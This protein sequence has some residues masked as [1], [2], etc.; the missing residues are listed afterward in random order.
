M[1]LAILVVGKGIG[2]EK[3]ANDHLL[4]FRD[5]AKAPDGI[6]SLDRYEFVL[7]HLSPT[8]PEASDA[9]KGKILGFS[10][11]QVPENLRDFEIPKFEGLGGRPSILALPWSSVP[12]NFS[13][14]AS[15]LLELLK[16]LS[17][18]FLS[19]L[20]VLCQGYLVL[21]SNNNEN[22]WQSTDV[23]EALKDMAFD[24]SIYVPTSISGAFDAMTES[25]WWR[26]IFVK[27]QNEL[28]EIIAR[29][30]GTTTFGECPEAVARLVRSIYS[31]HG[32]TAT[33][34]SDAYLAIASKLRT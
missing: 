11:G 14:D 26:A 16:P 5:S 12:A 25:T 6:L 28:E 22:D 8:N 2:T 13:G 31:D 15:Q 7:Q 9:W 19:A 33:V 24:D 27:E 23:K 3:V 20:V 10:G 17:S 30:W 4:D 34:V 1:S 29:E 32:I 18:Q 21:G